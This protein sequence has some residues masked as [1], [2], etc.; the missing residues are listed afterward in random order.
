[1]FCSE[2]CSYAAFAPPPLSLKLETRSRGLKEQQQQHKKLLA[3]MLSQDSFDSAHSP[4]PSITTEDEMEDEDDAMELLGTFSFVQLSP[5]VSE[6]ALHH[7][8]AASQQACEFQ[9]L[10]GSGVPSWCSGFHRQ[11]KIF[12]DIR[13]TGDANRLLMLV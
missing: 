1:M 10:L 11:S 8:A 3:A 5:D 9:G 6:A 13:L 2:S 4:A 12:T 7:C